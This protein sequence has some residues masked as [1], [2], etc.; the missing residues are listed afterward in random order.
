MKRGCAAL[1]NL[2]EMASVYR[3][4]TVQNLASARSR[5]SLA[6]S[7]ARVRV[8]TGRAPPPLCATPGPSSAATAARM[9]LGTTPYQPH[10]RC[11]AVSRSYARSPVSALPM[12]PPALAGGGIPRLEGRSESRA[13]RARVRRPSDHST[14][15]LAVK[16][17][18]PPR[19]GTRRTLRS[20]STRASVY[21]SGTRSEPAV[22][23]SVV[24]VM[25]L[26]GSDRANRLELP[27]YTP[28][29]PGPL[30]RGRG[31]PVQWATALGSRSRCP[32]TSHGAGLASCHA[33]HPH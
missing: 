26:S 17:V 18:R 21:P 27:L 10:S 30:F 6:S 25:L 19:V 16:C 33:L 15:P 4:R 12:V 13:S 29:S 1:E 28:G 5:R 9:R 7:P 22:V 32:L 11:S 8:D 23:Y 14:A 2:P 24:L 3:T 31:P 20:G